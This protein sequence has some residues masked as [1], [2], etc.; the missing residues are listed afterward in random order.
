MA[1]TPATPTVENPVTISIIGTGSGTGGGVAPTP[2]GTVAKTPAGQPNLRIQ[3]ITP[4]IAIVVRALNVFATTF[5][6]ALGA[7][8]VGVAPSTWTWKAAAGIALGAAIL[9]TAKN[10]ITIFNRLEGKWPLLTG[11]I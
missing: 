6:G 3:V 8:A 11:S 4:V 10:S 1:D 7:G 2:D 9:E 5:V